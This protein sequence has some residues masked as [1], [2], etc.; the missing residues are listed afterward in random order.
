MRYKVAEIEDQ[1]LATILA[2]TSNFS[3]LKTLQT[4]AGQVSAQMFNNPEWMQGFI[5]LLPFVL[6]SY[7]GRTST[8][9]DWDSSG[10]TRLHLIKF[11]IYTGAQSGRTTKEAVR[12]AYDMLGA[13]FDDLHAK[14]P[15]TSAQQLPGYTPLSGTALTSSGVRVLGPLYSNEGNDETL[16]VNIP[17]IVVYSSDFFL[18]MLA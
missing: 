15:V 6:V 10:K 7:Q 3:G 8:K 4:F 18:K 17:G 12:G 9:A 2:D 5:A 14:V 1:I 13:V 16:V 11:R